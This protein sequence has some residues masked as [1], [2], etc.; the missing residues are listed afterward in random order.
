MDR[1]TFAKNKEDSIG[2]L[3][4]AR[5]S[6]RGGEQASKSHDL[7][8][9]LKVQIDFI[10]LKMLLDGLQAKQKRQSEINRKLSSQVNH[11]REHFLE[12][13]EAHNLLAQIATPEKIIETV[14]SVFTPSYVRINSSPSSAINKP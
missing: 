10:Q 2:S 7:G 9:I 8:E 14:Q 11:L 12:Q 5:S 13:V 1:L 3:L 4:S 6:H